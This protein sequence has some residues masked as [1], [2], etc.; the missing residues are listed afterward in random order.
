[1]VFILLLAILPC[2][3]QQ[4]A[5]SATPASKAKMPYE[6]TWMEL[7]KV[8][9]SYVVYNYPRVYYNPDEPQRDD[10]YN[11]YIDSL[12]NT[13]PIVDYEWKWEW[14]DE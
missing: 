4:S 1:M 7:S 9:E 6:A 12:Y 8:G 14:K 2:H 11:L 10:I 5:A 13:F 3:S